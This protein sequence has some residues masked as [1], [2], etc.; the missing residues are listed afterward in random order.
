[1]PKYNNGMIEVQHVAGK[2][3]I[4]HAYGATLI[5]TTDLDY[6]YEYENDEKAWSQEVEAQMEAKGLIKYSEIFGAYMTP[7]DE[8]LSIWWDDM[9]REHIR[10]ESRSDIFI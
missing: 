2:T 8:Q 5:H 10:Q 7:E 1:M 9:E 6:D 3:W 4:F